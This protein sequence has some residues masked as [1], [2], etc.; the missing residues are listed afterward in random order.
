MAMQIKTEYQIGNSEWLGPPCEVCGKSAIL[1][2]WDY[3]TFPDKIGMVRVA[4]PL[5][6]GV[7][8][9]CFEHQRNPTEYKL[10]S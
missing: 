5:P 1:F 7:H 4:R 2:I 6:D 8:Y 10:D 9:F 3:E